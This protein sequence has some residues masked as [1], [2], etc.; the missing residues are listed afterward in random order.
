[1]LRKFCFYGPG[2][3]S[4]PACSISLWRQFCLLQRIRK[5]FTVLAWDVW[6][7]AGGQICPS[8]RFVP[9]CSVVCLPFY[10]L[11][12]VRHLLGFTPL[13]GSLIRHCARG[14]AFGQTGCPFLPSTIKSQLNYK[15]LCCICEENQHF[16]SNSFSPG[17]FRSEDR[18][19][20]K[21]QGYSNWVR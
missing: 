16:L 12:R 20:N 10:L 19:V 18:M 6:S 1:M 7:S 17:V 15:T 3:F 13:C 21:E 4:P 14:A 8:S 5:P 2:A 9:S 11:Y